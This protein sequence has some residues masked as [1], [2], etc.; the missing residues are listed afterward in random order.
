MTNTQSTK[1]LTIGR[2]WVNDRDNGKGTSPKLT[3]KLDRNLGINITLAP[4]S[5][6]VAFENRKRPGRQDADYRVA[7][8][9]PSDIADAEI[10]RQRSARGAGATAAQAEPVAA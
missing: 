4:G 5:Q 8:N 6:I 10:A 1:L 9:L 7:V 2:M 3:L